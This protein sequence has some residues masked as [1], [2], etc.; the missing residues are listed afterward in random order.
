MGLFDQPTTVIDGKGA[1][2]WDLQI[3]IHKLWLEG[4]GVSDKWKCWWW[5][6]PLCSATSGDLVAGLLFA[7]CWW[8]WSFSGCMLSASKPKSTGI[9]FY[10]VGMWPLTNQAISLLVSHHAVGGVPHHGKNRTQSTGVNQRVI[11]MKLRREKE[12]SSLPAQMTDDSSNNSFL[13]KHSPPLITH[14]QVEGDQD[15]WAMTL[16]TN[17]DNLC[18]LSLINLLAGDRIHSN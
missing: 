15:F 17:Q 6:D 13:S 11:W 12:N 9:W 18:F 10:W 14:N 8:T 4:H 7:Q 5:L 16:Q 2:Q 1:H 3:L